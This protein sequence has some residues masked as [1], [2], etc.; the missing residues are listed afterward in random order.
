MATLSLR[1]FASYSHDPLAALRSMLGERD[2]LVL[3]AERGPS[4]VG[5]AIVGF[6]ALPRDFGPWTR[7]TVARL[8]AIAVTPGMQGRGVGRR[9][10][11]SV[12]A[13]A[14]RRGSVSLSLNTA[15][16]NRRARR[17]FEPSGFLVVAT[18]DHFYANDQSALA[19]L[20]PLHL[21]RT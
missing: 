7:P 15:V 5:F 13:A 4:R 16:G 9:L 1:V 14:R 3:V 10:L 18:L 21:R 2:V 20:K 12:E 6:E 17:L 8:N 11:A 19:M